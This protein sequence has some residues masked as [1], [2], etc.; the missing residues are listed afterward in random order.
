MNNKRFKRTLL[1]T[2]V[3][4]LMTLS[5]SANAEDLFGKVASSSGA[6]TEL[7]VTAV[8]VDTGMERKISVD[9]DGKYRIPKLPTGIY[10]VSVSRGDTV[11][12]EKNTVSD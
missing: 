7:V 10:T 12:A 8:N 5:M 6:V 11:V 4:T 9:A 1:A 2:S 3:A